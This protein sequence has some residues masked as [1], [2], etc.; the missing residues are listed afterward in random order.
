MP[1]AVGPVTFAAVIVPVMVPSVV[2]GQAGW[3]PPPHRNIMTPP[4]TL[5]GAKCRCA[6]ASGD[7]KSEK[8]NEKV[9]MPCWIVI[10]KSPAPA[11][12]IG[13]TSSAPLSLAEK[14][15]VCE[16]TIG[17]ASTLAV[18]A[19]IAQN[20]I[21]VVFIIVFLPF[22]ARSAPFALSRPTRLGSVSEK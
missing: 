15:S 18:S 22:E 17:A 13:G 19:A 9:M 2:A 12:L 7:D 20:P 8:V 5:L 10:S 11:V 21:F 4:A 1:W 6:T 3:P 16:L 14:C